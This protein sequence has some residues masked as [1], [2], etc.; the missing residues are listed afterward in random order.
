MLL[1]IL[2]RKHPPLLEVTLREVLTKILE[3]LRPS[4]R[5][6]METKL[7]KGTK[8]LQYLTVLIP[9]TTRKLSLL[10]SLVR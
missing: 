4:S 5:E 3:I 1:R 9:E 2:L 6:I 10:S 8:R 7:W